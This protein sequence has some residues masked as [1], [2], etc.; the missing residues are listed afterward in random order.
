[1]KLETLEAGIAIK[2][3][4]DALHACIERLEGVLGFEGKKNEDFRTGSAVGAVMTEIKFLDVALFDKIVW[5]LDFVLK[6]RY[7]TESANL[8]ILS[9]ETA[10]T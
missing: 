3:K 6:Q 10:N 2:N 9:D 8:K 7:D 1:M 4:M 5:N